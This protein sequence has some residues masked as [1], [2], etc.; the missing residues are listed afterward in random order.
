MVNLI[1]LR[2]NIIEIVKS[3]KCICSKWNY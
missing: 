2:F 1:D 3:E